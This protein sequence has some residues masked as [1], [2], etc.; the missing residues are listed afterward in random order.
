LAKVANIIPNNY[1]TNE[2]QVVK[3]MRLKYANRI[4]AILPNIYQK[5]KV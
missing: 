2:G 5:D 4:V 1:D 3:K